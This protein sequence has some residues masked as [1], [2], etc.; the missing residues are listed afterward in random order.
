VQRLVSQHRAPCEWLRL[1]EVDFQEQGI[2]PN[3]QAATGQDRS[4]D[5]TDF[6]V[7]NKR[8]V[9]QKLL[10]G[11]FISAPRFSKEVDVIGL[12]SRVSQSS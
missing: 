2:L 7:V 11:Q 5:F 3:F 12:L 8:T 6:D 9:I 4:F 10:L 1:P